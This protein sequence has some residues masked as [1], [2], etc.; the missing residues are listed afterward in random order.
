[1]VTPR[2]VL[3]YIRTVLFGKEND[4]YSQ[5]M[6]QYFNHLFERA[7]RMPKVDAEGL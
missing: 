1:M 5:K 4:N 3:Y 2:D 7:E 6:S